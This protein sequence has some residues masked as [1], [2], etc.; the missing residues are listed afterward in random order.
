M[1]PIQA[2]NLSGPLTKQTKLI[3]QLLLE[4]QRIEFHFR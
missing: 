1:F 2:A 4:I 3:G